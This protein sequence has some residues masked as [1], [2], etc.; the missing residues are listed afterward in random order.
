MTESVLIEISQLGNAGTGVN[1]Q[2]PKPLRNLAHVCAE[3]NAP[4]SRGAIANGG[5][6]E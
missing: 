4:R 6:V 1:R 2:L 5:G 3:G